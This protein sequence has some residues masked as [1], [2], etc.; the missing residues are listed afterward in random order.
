MKRTAIERSP[1]FQPSSPRSK[2]FSCYAARQELTRWGQYPGFKRA[3]YISKWRNLAW[4]D[5]ESFALH[6]QDEVAAC[7]STAAYRR[8]RTPFTFIAAYEKAVLR[9]LRAPAGR[10]LE[11]VYMEPHIDQVFGF[12][13]EGKV[14]VSSSLS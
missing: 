9:Q 14:P 2:I 3:D 4:T 10:I 5:P 13:A 1:A 7:L 12:R 6:E 11:Q 8:E